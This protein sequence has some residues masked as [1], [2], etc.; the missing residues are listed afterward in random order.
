MICGLR[1]SRTAKSLISQALYNG[2]ERAGS[3]QPSPPKI[4]VSRRQSELYLH[5]ERKTPSPTGKEDFAIPAD[6]L[7][8]NQ[9]LADL[10]S[11]N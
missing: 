6:V 1:R 10:L 2:K 3:L 8:E 4:G 7:T 5:P 9:L 11:W